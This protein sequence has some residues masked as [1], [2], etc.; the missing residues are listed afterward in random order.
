MTDANGSAIRADG[1][2]NLEVAHVDRTCNIR[3]L[4]ADVERPLASLSAVADEGIQSGFR[5]DEAAR[6][7]RGH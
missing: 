4:D 3:L 6:C 7:A 1:E 2:V 5:F